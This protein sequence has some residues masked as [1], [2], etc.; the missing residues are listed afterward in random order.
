[1]RTVWRICRRRWAEQPKLVWRGRQHH[2]RGPNGRKQA[3]HARHQAQQQHAQRLL[4]ERLHG[5]P[6]LGCSDGS[7]PALSLESC[8]ERSGMIKPMRPAAFLSRTE[9]QIVDDSAFLEVSPRGVL[10]RMI[11]FSAVYCV[12]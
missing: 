1:M 7:G 3:Q 2:G 6:K 10:E 4:R 9:S 8:S 11:A 12:F 5:A